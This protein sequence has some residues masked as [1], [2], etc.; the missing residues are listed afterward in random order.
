[1][2]LI[3]DIKKQLE[4]FSCAKGKIVTIHTSL[5]AIGKTEGNAEA[6]LETLIEY[7]T[8]E[9]GLFCVPTHTWNS[10]VFDMNTAESCT[11]VLSKLAAAHPDGVRTLHPT[12]SMAVFGEKNK[13]NEFVKDEETVNSPTHPKGCYGKIYDAGGYVLLVGVGHEKNTYI[14][15]VE[16]MLKVPNRITDSMVERTIIYKDG[17]SHK[18]HIRWFDTKE[19]SDVSVY[20]GKFE[21]AFRYHGCITDGFI[22]NAPAQLCDA[23]K[24]KDVIELVYQKSNGKEFLNNHIPLDEK[25][26]KQ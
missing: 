24:M 23:K 3:K 14:H 6:L 22:G 20:F 10:N 9:G 1:M 26:Y 12:H 7:F 18:R 4:Q 25:L 13:V 5:K 15:C 11:G 19:I 8:D 2:F 17:T 21:P 16:E